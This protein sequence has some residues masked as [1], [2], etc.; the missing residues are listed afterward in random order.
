MVASD[1]NQKINL[2]ANGVTTSIATSSNGAGSGVFPEV[3]CEVTDNK[4]NISVE[5]VNG[6]WYKADNFHLT[7]LGHDLTLKE[8]GVA[9]SIDDWYTSVTVNRTIKAVCD[10][11]GVGKWNTFVVP[12]DM[13]IPAGWEVKKLTGS[14]VNGDNMT[15][16]FSDASAIEA[17]V[18]YMVRVA[19]EVTSIEVENVTVN[20]TLD[21]ASTGDI[22]F[23]GVYESGNVPVGTFFIS[24]NKFYHATGASNTIKAFRAYLAPVNAN[25]KAVG[26]T[27]DDMDAT[28]IEGVEDAEK[29][30]PVAVYGAD[31]ALRAGLQKGL[32]IVKMSDGKVKKVFVK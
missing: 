12:F 25:I 9:G 23:V 14:T 11:D 29:A 15:L 22:E 17:G 5:G 32:N 1:A 30:E 19:E 27:F 2:T 8:E 16:N 4:L 3:T 13:E 18:P 21:N 26:Y 24:D 6:I 31:G 20:T 10:G 28:V 7:Y